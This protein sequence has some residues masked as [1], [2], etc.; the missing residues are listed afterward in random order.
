MT[1]SAKLSECRHAKEPAQTQ[2]ERPE[3]TFVLHDA[4]GGR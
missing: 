4:L 1:L 2:L 3:W